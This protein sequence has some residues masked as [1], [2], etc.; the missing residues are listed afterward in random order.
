MCI[1]L[2]LGIPQGLVLW[3]TNHQQPKL[4]PLEVPTKENINLKDDNKY[5]VVPCSILNQY[6]NNNNKGY[7]LHQQGLHTLF[8]RRKRESI[9][10]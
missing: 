8:V 5:Q 4:K 2:L 6:N 1:Y 9:N 10:Y 3:S 7:Q